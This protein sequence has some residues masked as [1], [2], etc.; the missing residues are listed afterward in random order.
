MAGSRKLQEGDRTLTAMP[1]AATYVCTHVWPYTLY[2]PLVQ[3]RKDT[4]V[5][6][7]RWQCNCGPEDR[8]V[9]ERVYKQHS[10][11]GERQSLIAKGDS[12]KVGC[13][14]AFEV[15]ERLATPGI[16]RIR[17]ATSCASTWR[18]CTYKQQHCVS[19]LLSSLLRP[20]ATQ[21]KP[22]MY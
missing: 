22:C 1:F 21:R 17:Y 15:T 3:I 12:I 5:Y 20:H 2:C 18:L 14:A 10:A 9:S 13:R 7:A 8:R 16:L 19:Y 11:P 4:I 6:T